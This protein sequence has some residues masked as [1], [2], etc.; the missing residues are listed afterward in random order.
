M[1]SFQR[2]LFSFHI[3]N[4]WILIPWSLNT[5]FE[6]FLTI[7]TFWIDCLSRFTPN[8]EQG[9][10]FVCQIVNFAV[11]STNYNK[12]RFELGSTQAEAVELL[13]YLNSILLIN[14]L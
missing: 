10:L 11:I 9:W 7:K 2:Y 1:L 3:L 6:N 8:F 4:I 5:D 12:L 13:F 14:I